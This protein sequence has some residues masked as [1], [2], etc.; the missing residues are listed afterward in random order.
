LAGQLRGAA[1]GLWRGRSRPQACGASVSLAG[2][3]WAEG[4]NIRFVERYATDNNEIAAQAP[5]LAGLVPDSIFLSGNAALQA[6]RRASRDIPIVF[7]G[8]ADPVGQGFVSSLAHPGG[9]I[10]GFANSEFSIVTQQLDLLK[11]LAPTLE[12]VAYLY[13]P[14]QA[15]SADLVARFEAGAASLALRASK[16]PVRNSEEIERAI[17]AV[18][19]EP[20]SSLYLQAV[21]VIALNR[22]M[23]AMLALRYRLP[24]MHPFRIYVE[25]SGLASYGPDQIDMCRRAA[26]YV[27]RILRGEKPRDL[28]V[29][30]P[31]KVDF[32]INLKTARALG[33]EVPPQLLAL[34]EVI[35]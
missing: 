26:S 13:D 27:D 11:K 7:A 29:Q 19:R 10:T 17:V 21:P 14:D 33:I 1:S 15:V 16:L 8:V 31:A 12:R 2:L 25:S 9:N 32:I 28:P 18:A 24:T 20:D 23:I 35:D 6:M 3:G 22:E 4:R 30:L 34:A 5:E